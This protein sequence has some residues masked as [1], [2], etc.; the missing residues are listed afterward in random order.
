MRKRIQKQHS[1]PAEP[2]SSRLRER[3]M[4]VTRSKQFESLKAG[5]SRDTI[6]YKIFW[7]ECWLSILTYYF[8]LFPILGNLK[9]NINWEFS[10]E[11]LPSWVPKKQPSLP[12][13]PEDSP[14]PETGEEEEGCAKG[15]G[16]KS[17]ENSKGKKQYPKQGR[18]SVLCE[19]PVS[20]DRFCQKN[21]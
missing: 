3:F 20:D 10:I 2:Q 5:I 14:K 19:L 8:Q 6:Q 7:L 21:P 15:E 17:E 4:A 11:S 13:E 12:E 16:S 1:L 18:Y 9:P